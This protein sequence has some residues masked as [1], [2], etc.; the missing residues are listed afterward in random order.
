MHLG[1]LACQEV[2]EALRRHRVEAVQI[3]YAPGPLDRLSPLQ[4]VH[5]RGLGAG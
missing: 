2:L 1:S 3:I 4:L 5:V